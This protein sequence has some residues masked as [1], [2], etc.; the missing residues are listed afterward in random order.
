MN[1][2]GAMQVLDGLMLGDGNLVRFRNKVYYQMTQSK[3]TI[4]I[5]DHLKWLYWLR[6]NVFAVL[7]IKATVSSPWIA[8]PVGVNKGRKHQVAHL[9]TERTS[10]LV[11]FFDEWYTGGKWVTPKGHER[12]P[13]SYYVR[14]AAKVIPRRLML[15]SSL[16]V[17]SLTH[18]FLGDG[19][20]SNSTTANSFSTFCFTGGEVYHL[21]SMLNNMGIGTV[22]PVAYTHKKGS[23]LAIYLSQT[24]INYFMSLIEPHV[25]E[26]FGDSVGPSYKDM[27]KYRPGSRTADLR[28]F[29]DLR[30]RMGVHKCQS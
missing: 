9:R 7:N 26:I 12:F 20:R 23:G 4:S 28:L 27:I 25:L 2:E 10:I 3:H 18:F 1:N 8:Y 19:G 11:K 5:E 14:G 6:D 15:A 24:S 13:S 16:P 21:M 30:S 22:E 29:G 17:Y